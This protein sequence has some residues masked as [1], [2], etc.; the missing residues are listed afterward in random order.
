MKQI[1]LIL[2]LAA[3]GIA[4]TSQAQILIQHTFDG[5]SGDLNGTSLDTNTIGAAPGMP[6]W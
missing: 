5:G 1:K 2:V 3:L 6:D 4:S